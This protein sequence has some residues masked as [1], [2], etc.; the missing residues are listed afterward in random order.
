MAEMRQFRHIRRAFLRFRIR[1]SGA[2]LAV[3]TAA[4]TVSL[5][6]SLSVLGDSKPA[7]LSYA[8][9][10]GPPIVMAVLPAVA[11][12]GVGASVR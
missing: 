10:F 11:P 3:P 5:A 1:E 9:T 8:D 7:T 2:A 4:F 6:T 12:S